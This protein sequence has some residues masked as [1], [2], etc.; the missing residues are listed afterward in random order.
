MSFVED[1]P[2][3]CNDDKYSDASRFFRLACGNRPRT[4]WYYRAREGLFGPFESKSA[5]QHHLGEVI[6]SDL[7]RCI[8][9][10]RRLGVDLSRL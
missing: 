7:Q 9:R 2:P 3:T 4:G 1:A 8:E 5:A 10:Y 6:G